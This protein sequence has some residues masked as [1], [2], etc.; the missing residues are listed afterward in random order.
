[1][2]TTVSSYGQGVGQSAIADQHQEVDVFFFA[3]VHQTS[4]LVQG[5]IRVVLVLKD[6][7]QRQQPQGDVALGRTLHHLHFILDCPSREGKWML[8]YRDS[9]VEG[10]H[11]E[12]HL[13][14]RDQLSDDCAVV[15]FVDCSHCHD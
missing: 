3:T 9:L 1:M 12:V 10:G 15:N 13:V 2:P 5:V 8:T 11:E 7:R 14:H 4:H 6:G